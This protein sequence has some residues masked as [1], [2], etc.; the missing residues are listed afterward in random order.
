MRSQG[1]A[2][3]NDEA[4]AGLSGSTQP[5]GRGYALRCVAEV[6]ISFA[7]RAD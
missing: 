3:V 5:F 7:G 1:A 4:I 6:F 2:I